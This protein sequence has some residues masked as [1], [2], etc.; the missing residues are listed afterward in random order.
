MEY[1]LQTKKMSVYLRL[2]KGT[3]T[4]IMGTM[5]AYLIDKFYDMEDPS[6]SVIYIWKVDQ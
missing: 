6:E 3:E 2:D 1:L 5:H 4:E